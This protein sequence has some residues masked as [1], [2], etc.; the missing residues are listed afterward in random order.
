MSF[1]RFDF[2]LF[3]GAELAYDH[4]TLNAES[5]EPNFLTIQK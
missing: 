4:A 1:K 2:D 3:A 5:V